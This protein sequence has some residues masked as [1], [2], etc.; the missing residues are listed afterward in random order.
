MPAFKNYSTKEFPVSDQVA[1]TTIGLPF[2]RDLGDEE[3]GALDSLLTQL[4]K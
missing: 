1:S 3:M 2:F 4:H